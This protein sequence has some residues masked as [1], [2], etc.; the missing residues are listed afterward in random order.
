MR[1]QGLMG[2]CSYAKQIQSSFKKKFTSRADANPSCLRLK[3]S[4]EPAIVTSV[5]S[6][7]IAASSLNFPANDREKNPLAPTVAL[8]SPIS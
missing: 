1:L 2:I 6:V 4:G 5:T 8:S 7:T 3:L